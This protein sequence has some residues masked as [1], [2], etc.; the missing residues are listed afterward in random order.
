MEEVDGVRLLEKTF[1]DARIDLRDGLEPIYANYV[2]ARFSKYRFALDFVQIMPRATV[3]RV[4]ARISMTPQD[5]LAAGRHVG[6]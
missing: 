2:V 5:A 6:C 4:K 3:H 1:Q